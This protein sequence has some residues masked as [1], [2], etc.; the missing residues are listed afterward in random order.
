MYLPIESVKA[1][2]NKKGLNFSDE[3][4]RTVIDAVNGV[5]DERYFGVVLWQNEDIVQGLRI[6]GVDVS[7]DDDIVSEIR[8]KLENNDFEDAMIERGW[9]DVEFWIEVVLKEHPEL[10]PNNLYEAIA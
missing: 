1:E 8:C 4:I 10:V 6:Y 5:I 7:D 3:T 9:G 2:F